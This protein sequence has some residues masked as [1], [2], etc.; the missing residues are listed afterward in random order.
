MDLLYADDNNLLLFTPILLVTTILWDNIWIILRTC[1]Q[2]CSSFESS[3]SC[4]RSWSDRVCQIISWHGD[5]RPTHKSW[6]WL[7]S[8]LS[9]SQTYPA[10]N[11][12]LVQTVS[13]S[14]SQTDP[15]WAGF[16]PPSHTHTDLHTLGYIYHPLYY[17]QGTQ[18]HESHLQWG[19]PRPYK[20]LQR[21][22]HPLCTQ[23]SPAVK[24]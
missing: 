9:H 12:S 17:T 20:V 6:I 11:G 19:S 8:L 4:S 3:A 7:C 15:W 22:I 14:L 23:C 18:N 24:Y 16:L 10:L 5:E 21:N 2:Y 13:R 1:L